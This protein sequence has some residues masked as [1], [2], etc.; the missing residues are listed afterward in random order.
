MKP[1][2]WSNAS[3]QSRGYGKEWQK[4]RLVVLKRDRYLCQCQHC[5]AEGR[6]TIASEVD[7]VVSKAQATKLGWLPEQVDHPSNL[8]AINHDCHV[9]K[10]M[11]EKGHKP[12]RLI[13]L[14]GFPVV[15]DVPSPM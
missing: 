13:G 11:E 4:L 8:Q 1:N 10:T 7:H 15:V 3:R 2:K 14:D 12:A 6:V 9:I 5:K